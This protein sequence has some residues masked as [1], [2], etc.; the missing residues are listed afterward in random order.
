MRS[1][2]RTRPAA[3]YAA[4]RGAEVEA[5]RGTLYVALRRRRER[6][7]SLR[8]ATVSSA[9]SPGGS[10]GMEQPLRRVVSA[11]ERLELPDIG[12]TAFP[13]ASGGISVVVPLY[14]ESARFE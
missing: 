4:V 9:W 12:T 8:G 7:R 1:P 10:E 14:N 5:P 6:R 2:P 3:Q 13:I 11:R